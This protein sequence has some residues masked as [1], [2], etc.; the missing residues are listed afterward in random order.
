MWASCGQDVTRMPK[1]EHVSLQ[2]GAKWEPGFKNIHG[3]QG[4]ACP[5]GQ[6]KKNI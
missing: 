6:C 5:G 3:M 2:A 1:M 4:C